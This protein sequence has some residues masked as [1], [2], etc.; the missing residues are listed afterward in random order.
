MSFWDLHDDTKQG[1][2][3]LSRGYQAYKRAKGFG[4]GQV[5]YNN[6]LALSSGRAFARPSSGSLRPSYRKQGRRSFKSRRS[7]KGGKGRSTGLRKSRF[8]KAPVRKRKAAARK[9][10]LGIISQG[11]TVDS[12]VERQ[13]VKHVAST[14]EED[15]QV[16]GLAA[17]NSG[18]DLTLMWH[19]TLTAQSASPAQVL[20]KFLVF[21]HERTVKIHPGA[22]PPMYMEITK[23]VPRFDSD[24]TPTQALALA[25]FGD[26]NAADKTIIGNTLFD[27][28]WWCTAYK[29]VKTYKRTMVRGKA[30]VLR[31]KRNFK[32]G[33]LIDTNG[34][35]FFSTTGAHPS[36]TLTNFNF[37]QKKGLSAVLTYRAMGA[38]IASTGTQ[39][40]TTYPAFYI[41]D[42]NKVTYAPCLATG[43]SAFV[44]DY[45]ATLHGG[46]GTQNF[47]ATSGQE[48]V[49]AAGSI[50]T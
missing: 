50:I 49:I 7:G 10:K 11:V 2:D 14:A 3:Y 5:A 47:I 24:E 40:T 23:W 33:K 32:N 25:S 39:N 20:G 31:F 13:V 9:A 48:A 15:H 6:A 30:W 21:S 46:S 44:S 27:C 18:F 26:L 41:E 42:I 8:G 16:I 29:A 22:L 35:W 12:Y 34:E 36:E 43:K 37:I 38:A 45:S 28:H 19:L 1:M 17:T 4:G